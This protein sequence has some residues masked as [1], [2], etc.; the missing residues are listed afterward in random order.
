MICQKCKD[1]NKKSC[2]YDSGTISTD[3]ASSHYYDE[4]GHIHFHNP[5]SHTQSFRCSNGHN[6][7]QVV[8]DKCNR[9]GYNSGRDSIKLYED[10]Q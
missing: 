9:C 7:S 4:D 2:V 5:N 10:H 3:M 6:F 8:Y 1:E